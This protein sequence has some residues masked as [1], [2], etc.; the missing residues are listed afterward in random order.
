MAGIPDPSGAESSQQK[1]S[2]QKSSDVKSSEHT[3]HE[4]I[5][6]KPGYWSTMWHATIG[7]IFKHFVALS[8]TL[9]SIWGVAELFTYTLGVNAKLFDTLPIV[10]LIH[11]GDAIA[12]L[13]FIWSTIKD[14]KGD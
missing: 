10:Y 6:A 13:R 5:P 12:F 4:S 8:L 2:E 3:S 14:F 7:P 9:L 1:A 11:T